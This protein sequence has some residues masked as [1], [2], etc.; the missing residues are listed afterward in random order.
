MTPAIASG[1][2]P[3]LRP[4]DPERAHELALAGLRLGLAG[5]HGRPDDP[6]L[7]VEV[8]GRKFANPTGLAAGFDKNAV[9]IGPLARL[10]FGFVEAGSVTPRP[11]AGNPRPHLFRLAQEPGF[12]RYVDTE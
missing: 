6:A 10:G 9:A 7:A 4:F 5:R 11:Q 1:L 8:L 12:G 3:L 2:L